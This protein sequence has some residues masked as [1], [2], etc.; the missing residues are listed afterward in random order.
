M[1]GCRWVCKQKECKLLSKIEKKNNNL[2]K[3]NKQGGLVCPSEGSPTKSRN[4]Y[5]DRNDTL[6]ILTHVEND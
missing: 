1:A 3:K 5:R 2:A 4:D 6:G